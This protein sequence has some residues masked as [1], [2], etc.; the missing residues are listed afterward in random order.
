M[1]GY[2]IEAW[3][4]LFYAAMFS[5]ASVITIKRNPWISMMMSSTSIMLI[6]TLYLAVG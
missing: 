5:F 2:S 1:L 6:G 4:V 3:T